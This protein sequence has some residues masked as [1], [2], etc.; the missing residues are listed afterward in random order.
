MFFFVLRCVRSYLL[1]LKGN[2]GERETDYYFTFQ[3][4]EWYVKYS[5]LQLALFSQFQ[6]CAVG[7][8]QKR[9]F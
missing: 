5:L 6:Y 4:N 1:T 3:Q 2:A 9:L 8:E 7:E